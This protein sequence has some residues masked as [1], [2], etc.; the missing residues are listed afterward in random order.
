MTFSIEFLSTIEHRSHSDA[1]P[2]VKIYSR[3]QA[4]ELFQKFTEVE[5]TTEHCLPE[6][7]PLFRLKASIPRRLAQLLL[8]WHNRTHAFGWYL[9]IKAV[10]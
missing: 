1:Q 3:S 8:N 10:K 6:H 5:I 2:L 9:I 4:R 7:I